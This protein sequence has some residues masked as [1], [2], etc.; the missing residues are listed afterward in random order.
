MYQ[1]TQMHPNQDY[2][3]SPSYSHESHNQDYDSQ[4]S[5]YTYAMQ[6]EAAPYETYDKQ[7]VVYPITP[8]YKSV[9]QHDQADQPLYA[10]IESHTVQLRETL[11]A[12]P[13]VL[14]YP[15]I[16]EKVVHMFIRV[17][18][19]IID[20]FLVLQAQQIYKSAEFLATWN[21]MK[22]F[23]Q[24]V[25]K[26]MIRNRSNYELFK[27][28]ASSRLVVLEQAIKASFQPA[29]DWNN[30]H[31]KGREAQK[32]KPLTNRYIQDRVNEILYKLELITAS[33]YVSDK[34]GTQSSNETSKAIQNMFMILIT[35]I[36]MEN[37]SL[38]YAITSMFNS[39]RRV[40][41]Q[42]ARIFRIVPTDSTVFYD[43]VLSGYYGNQ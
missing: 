38:D 25:S 29:N 42:I 2:H 34:K 31:A 39:L 6:Q 9:L 30:P 14:I 4:S 13:E 1:T 41:N 40:N 8:Q 35:R 37:Y 7:Q 33:V 28:H 24:I 26:H 43:C 20:F 3:N 16:C 15:D 36:A 27:Q 10:S 12:H 23:I 17:I 11:K 18:E 5:S 22:R 32:P 21:I 19:E